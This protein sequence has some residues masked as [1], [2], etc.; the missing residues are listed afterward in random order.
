MTTKQISP[1]VAVLL[2]GQLPSV[3]IAHSGHGIVD[4]HSVFFHWIVDHGF[5]VGLLVAIAITVVAWR[6]V[7]SEKGK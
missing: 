5:I 7:R 6:S 4:D 1:L 2:T 3:A